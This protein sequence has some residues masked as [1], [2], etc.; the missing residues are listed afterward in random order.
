MRPAGP[1]KSE[2]L[3]VGFL[4]PLGTELEHQVLGPE[5]ESTRCLAGRQGPDSRVVIEKL[6]GFWTPRSWEKGDWGSGTLGPGRE[7]ARSRAPWALWE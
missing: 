1:R 4:R 3:G 6:M 7:R 5:T 2:G